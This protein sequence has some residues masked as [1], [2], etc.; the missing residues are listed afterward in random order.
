[1]SVCMCVS[2]KVDEGKSREKEEN[3]M[4]CHRHNWHSFIGPEKE[5]SSHHQMTILAPLSLSSSLLLFIL[6]PICFAIICPVFSCSSLIWRDNRRWTSLKAIYKHTGGTVSGAFFKVCRVK[7]NHV[8]KSRGRSTKGHTKRDGSP[9]SLSLSLSL[10]VVPVMTWISE[11]AF[12]EDKK[13]AA[14][15]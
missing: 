15:K 5:H 2:M 14:D 3:R 7:M 12:H 9:L 13:D 8:I 11:T 10:I 6:W 4:I 1:M